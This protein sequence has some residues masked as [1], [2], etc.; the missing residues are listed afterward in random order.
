MLTVVL[1][2]AAP[3]LSRVTWR[4]NGEFHSVLEVIAT[5]LALTTG[6]IALARY[7]AKRSAKFLLIGVGFSSISNHPALSNPYGVNATFFQ[8]DP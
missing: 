4:V 7:Y 8:A 1:T 6:A 2:A 3:I 5:Q